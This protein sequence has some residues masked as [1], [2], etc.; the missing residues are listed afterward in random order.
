MRMAGYAH[1][2]APPRAS[3]AWLRLSWRAFGQ[4]CVQE[5]TVLKTKGMYIRVCVAVFGYE[6]SHIVHTKD[7]R[8]VGFPAR[9]AYEKTL[10]M[11]NVCTQCLCGSRHPVVLR[12]P[13]CDRWSK[14]GTLG[15]VGAHS[16]RDWLR[17]QRFD[18]A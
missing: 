18:G 2:A 14:R 1:G 4:R 13:V 8:I 12:T 7:G 15:M 11:S 16:S 3:R 10:R 9:E 6:L 5:P 17:Q